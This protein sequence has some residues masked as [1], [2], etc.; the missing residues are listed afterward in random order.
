M[1][2]LVKF[3]CILGL[4][5]FI[6]A[7]ADGQLACGESKTA[8]SLREEVKNLDQCAVMAGNGNLGSIPM[9]I[10]CDV[11]KKLFGDTACA[12]SILP[13]LKA[14]PQ[15]DWITSTLPELCKVDVPVGDKCKATPSP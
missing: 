1:A 3:I 10:C 11:M 6:G 13:S 12:C 7:G 2:S 5:I 4:I 15:S 14:L 8:E 9:S